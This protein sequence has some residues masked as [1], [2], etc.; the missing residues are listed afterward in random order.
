MRLDHNHVQFFDLKTGKLLRK[1]EVLDVIQGSYS[2]CTLLGDKICRIDFPTN[3]KGAQ[4][5]SNLE[6]FK[7]CYENVVEPYHSKTLLGHENIV[8]DIKDLQNPELNIFLSAA[9]DGSI[10]H[11]NKENGQKIVA[12]FYNRQLN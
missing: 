9:W 5:F 1:I 12:V 7:L 2:Y 4:G 10:I 6:A 3:I 8:F 11:W